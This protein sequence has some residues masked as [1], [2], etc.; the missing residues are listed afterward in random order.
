M[1]SNVNRRARDMQLVF[2]GQVIDARRTMLDAGISDRSTLV[3][4]FDNLQVN[5][6]TRLGGGSSVTASLK[7]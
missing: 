3:M 1:N 7:M 6:K 4:N 5:R 2:Q